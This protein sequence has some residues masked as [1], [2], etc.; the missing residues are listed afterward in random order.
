[1]WA[2]V[3]R[4]F[5]LL[6]AAIEA[7]RGVLFKTIGDAVQAAFPTVPEADRGGGRRPGARCAGEDW[8]ELGPLR[9]R[10]AIHVGEA[11]PV[12]GDYLAPVLNRLSRV[13]SAGYGEQILLTAAARALAADASPRTRR[14]AISGSIGCAI[15]S[16]PSASTSSS[17]RA[18]RVEFPPLKTL[19]RQPHNLPSQPTEL[20][21][22]EAGAGAAR[23]R[24]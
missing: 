1:M 6:R 23:R 3:E 18:C 15:C 12:D 7:H 21:G 8:G 4:H 17:A 5:A 11:T 20:I 24:C 9:V 16:R 2:A 22:R 10:M 13:L 19:D 14:C